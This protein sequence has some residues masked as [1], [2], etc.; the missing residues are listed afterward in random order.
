MKSIKI[1]LAVLLSLIYVEAQNP[2]LRPGS[3]KP[4]PPPPKAYVPIP[5]PKPQNTNL[6]LRGYFKMKD[7]WF[8]SI[9]DKTTNKGMW[10]KAGE[11]V[12]DQQVN[13]ESF[14]QE[15]EVV[16]LENGV[17]LSLKK[18]DN[19]VLQVP[20]GIPVKKPPSKPVPKRPTLVI[21]PRTNPGK[22]TTVRPPSAQIRK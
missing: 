19:K 9:F 18:P 21:P 17:T 10:L 11:S 6:E 2:F 13:I 12:G 1:I 16:K 5:K 14:N 8:F 3:D 7:E 15:T 4:P 20:S 22:T